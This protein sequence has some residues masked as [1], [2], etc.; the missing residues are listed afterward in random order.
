M[1]AKRKYATEGWR[2]MRARH[3]MTYP[4]CRVC[5]D[6]NDV[7]VHHLRYGAQKGTT[8]QPGDLMTLCRSHHDD[9]HRK[10]KKNESLIDHTLA[11]VKA[12]SPADA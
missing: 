8:E 12:M 11:Y 2:K 7:A 1:R 10:H 4:E 3:L 6:E 9:L 5:G